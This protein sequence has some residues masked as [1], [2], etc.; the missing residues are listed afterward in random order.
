[1]GSDLLLL[2]T[3]SSAF[4]SATLLE[5]RIHQQSCVGAVCEEEYLIILLLVNFEKPLNMH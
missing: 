4:P 2:G 1:M 3:P 5:D